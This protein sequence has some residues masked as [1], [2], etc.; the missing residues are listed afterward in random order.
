VAPKAPTASAG[1]QR[2]GGQAKTR[3]IPIDRK[4]T[5]SPVIAD[6]SGIVAR[7]P[8]HYTSGGELPV[9]RFLRSLQVYLRSIGLYQRNHPRLTESLESTERDLRTVLSR[10]PTLGVRVENGNIYSSTRLDRLAAGDDS[11]DHSRTGFR[12]NFRNNG[13]DDARNDSGGRA[14]ADPHGE[15]RAL[16]EELSGAGVISLIFLPR[17]NLGELAIFAQAV[18]GACRIRKQ[19]QPASGF[20][21]R[22]WSAWLVEHDVSGIRV[23]VPSERRQ[24]AVL[25]SLLGALLERRSTSFPSISEAA[26]GGPALTRE[27]ALRT[28]HFLWLAGKHLDEAQHDSPQDAARAV[29]AELAGADSQALALTVSRVV[30]NPPQD[31]DT[32]G[33]YLERIGDELASEF[34]RGEYL[35]R[36]I[37]AAEIRLLF[38]QLYR[39]NGRANETESVF[40]ARIE[41]FWS[42]LPAREITR[43][44]GSPEGWCVPVLVLRRHLETLIAAAETRGAEAAGRE[45]RRSLDHFVRC[46]ESEEEKA[47]RTIAAGLVELFDLIEKIWP[48]PQLEDLAPRVV[49]ALARETSHSIAG[50]LVAATENLARMALARRGYAEVERILEDLDKAP[51][52]PEDGHIAALARRI[53]GQEQWLTLVDES[54]AN[55]ALDAALPRLLRREPQRLVDRLGLLLTESGGANSLPAMARLVRAAGEPVL[56]TLEARLAEPRRQRAATAIKL[57]SSVQPERLAAALP[58]VLAGWDWSLQ[59]LAVSELSRQPSPVLRLQAAQVF[60]SIVAEAHL[61]VVPSMIDQIALSGALTGESSAIPR[62]WAIAAGDVEQ[63]RD[64]F[65][66]IKAVEALGRLRATEAA[67]LLRNMVRQ[68]DGLA[69]AE[70]AGLRAAAEEALALMENHPASERVRAVQDAVSKMSV[71]FTVPRRYMRVM[72]SD[73]LPAKILAPHAGTGRVR[74]LALGGALLETPTRLAVGDSIRAEMRIGLRTI[75]STAVVRNAGM[76]GYGIEFMHMK[77]EDRE[78]LR[79]HLSKLLR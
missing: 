28:L 79:R 8:I 14:L 58:R 26:S 70:P 59:D 53:V 75:S 44:L 41:R 30:T 12:N 5:D 68:R 67:D 76:G 2:Q 3:L 38:E 77:P 15:L 72:L 65:V 25:G 9:A 20:A 55:R 52:E 42:A 34:V 32:A 62:L 31:G 27:Q 78:K 39:N 63:L 54:L 18:D 51:R 23:N 43:A 33:A 1:V 61:F 69:Y 71:A 16:A 21:G 10:F 48:D 60:L 64:I 7:A 45:A 13:R 56:G 11:D 17:I 36:R 47:R 22:D 66:R 50:L 37:R 73:P 6:P 74:S 4:T 57:L 49:A 29:Q 19:K 24:D 35:S 40:E 46:L